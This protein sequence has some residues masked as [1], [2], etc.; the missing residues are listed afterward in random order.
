MKKYFLAVLSLL[1]LPSFV[2]AAQINLDVDK[3]QLSTD[4]TLQ[5][6]LSVDGV[7]D[8][9]KVGIKGL[10]NFAVIGESSSQRIQVINGKTTA[11]QEK[12]L[13]VQPLQAGEFTIQAL[14][15]ENGQLVK[16]LPVKIVVNKSLVQATK[17]KLLS[18]PTNSDDTKNPAKNLLTQPSNNNQPTEQLEIK[19]L[20]K[21]PPVQH[22]SAFNVVF[23]LEFLGILALLSA[24][25]Y[26]L[27]KNFRG[28]L[29]F[30]IKK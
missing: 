20:P 3:T 19:E 1:M 13:Q 21:I 4:D 26:F 2:W 6:T 28:N 12:I 24:L 25:G 5:I 17:E 23:W 30:Y 29:L 8:D 11:I 9:G 15:Q 18:T 22:F 27:R 16:S 10:D 14:G 7:L